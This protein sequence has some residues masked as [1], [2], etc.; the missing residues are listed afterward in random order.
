M[1]GGD[2]RDAAAEAGRLFADAAVAQ[3]WDGEQL[4]GL[5]VARGFG[6]TDRPAWDIYLVYAPDAEWTDAGLPRADKVLAQSNG[7]VI[8][9]RGTLPPRGDQ[10]LVPDWGAG[11]VDVVGAQSELGSLMQQIAAPYATADAPR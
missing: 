10:S 11:K 5:E 8:G 6:I 4:L 7:V 9:I 3:F 1:L 2:D